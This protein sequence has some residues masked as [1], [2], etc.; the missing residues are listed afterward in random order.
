MPLDLS[1][2]RQPPQ[3]PGATTQPPPVDTG[4]PMLSWSFC[5]V[6]TSVEEL[7]EGQEERPNLVTAVPGEMNTP[8]GRAKVVL[9]TVRNST[10]TMTAFLKQDR[11]R[12]LIDDIRKALDDLPLI[13]RPP[14]GTPATASFVVNAPDLPTVAALTTGERKRL[15]LSLESPDGSTRATLD[16]ER[17]RALLSILERA[18]AALSGLTLG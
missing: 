11:A 9:I 2:L 18:L 17:A 10:T 1:S 13:I 16:P 15:L 12:D 4:N 14:A 3:P 8:E 6:S 5:Q 7:A